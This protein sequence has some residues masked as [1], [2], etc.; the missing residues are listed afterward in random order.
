MIVTSFLK[1]IEKLGIA[2]SEKDNEF[3]PSFGEEVARME[4]K[5]DSTIL[6]H[7]WLQLITDHVFVEFRHVELFIPLLV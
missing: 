1:S 3:K 6:T 4:L 7:E 5:N 2:A